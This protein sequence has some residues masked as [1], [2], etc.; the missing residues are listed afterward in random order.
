MKW[1][2]RSPTGYERGDFLPILIGG[3]VLSLSLPAF[4]MLL[5]DADPGAAALSLSLLVL[6]AAGILLGLGYLWVGIRVC[7]YPGSLPYRITHGRLV[8]RAPGIE[9]R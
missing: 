2:R 1:I 6:F 8:S 9:R 3:V 4:V 7:S 5:V